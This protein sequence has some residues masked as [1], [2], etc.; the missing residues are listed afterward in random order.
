L[1]A[2]I[3]LCQRQ[4][5]D[6]DYPD[7]TV[8]LYS[9]VFN[10][11]LDST[12]QLHMC[13]DCGTTA[14]AMFIALIKAH[15]RQ[16]PP[17]PLE[18][19]SIRRQY[20]Q[21]ERPLERLNELHTYLTT[22]PPPGPILVSIGLDGLGH[23][24]II[25]VLPHITP[26]RKARLRLYQSAHRAYTIVDSLAHDG[27]LTNPRKILNWPLLNTHLTHLFSTKVWQQEEINQFNLWFHFLDYRPPFRV[28][29]PRFG[30]AA[31]TY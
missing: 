7:H 30:W 9:R 31:L 17:T 1:A 18:M 14:R 11:I 29:E 25:E 5:K 21:S 4:E 24:F 19:I 16:E 22:N 15:R 26:R 3:A 28:R 13:Y 10:Q 12:R 2:I 8:R 6:L 27:L 20:T 23:V